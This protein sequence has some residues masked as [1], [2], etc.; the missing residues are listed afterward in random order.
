MP[1]GSVKP[2]AIDAVFGSVEVSVRKLNDAVLVVREGLARRDV[3]ELDAGLDDVRAASCRCSTSRDR[4]ARRC[5]SFEDERKARRAEDDARIRELRAGLER[6]LVVVPVHELQARLV[7]E[8]A[9][10]RQIPLAQLARVDLV[11]LRDAAVLRDLARR[12]CPRP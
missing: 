4:R 7:H 10:R 8:V 6:L 1:F 3:R 9:A 11:V 12:S 5:V 2:T